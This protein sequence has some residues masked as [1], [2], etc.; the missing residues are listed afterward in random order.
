MR[1]ANL[2]TD[3]EFMP[4]DRA[5][6]VLMAAGIFRA[7]SARTAAA[8]STPLPGGECSHLRFDWRKCN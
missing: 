8:A 2:T 1:V 6:R 3:V 4:V 5:L 7:W